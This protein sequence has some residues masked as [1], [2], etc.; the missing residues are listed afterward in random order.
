MKS[1]VAPL[2]PQRARDR[3][4]ERMYRRH[5]ADVYH[6]AL[7]VLH[8]EADAEDVTQTTFLNAYRAFTVGERPDKPKNWLIAIAHNVCRQ[9]FRTAARR[10]KEVPLI[11]ETV[12]DLVDDGDHPSAEDIRRALSHLSFNQRSALVMRE[13]EGRTYNEIA[14]IL[15]LSRSAV[16]TLIF[17]ARRALREQ[18][19]EALTCREAEAALS[20]RADAQLGWGER[21]ALRAHLR[22]CPECARIARRQRAQRVALRG[23]ATA[24]VPSSLAAF[25]AGGTATGGAVVAK[26]AAVAVVGLVVGAGTFTAVEYAIRDEQFARPVAAPPAERARV[27]APAAAP[28]ASAPVVAQRAPTVTFRPPAASHPARHPPHGRALGHPGKA[29]AERRLEARAERAL[30]AAARRHEHRRAREDKLERRAERALVKA[31]R[32]RSSHAPGRAGAG[33][34]TAHTKGGGHRKKGRR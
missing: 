20:R 29:R 1:L 30:V 34:K 28:A 21:R 33:R 17:R 7:A 3:V 23:L 6:Y 10:P 14:Q 22:E 16:E 8:N 13:L 32:H 9:R 25:F 12:A 11:E 18:L 2:F 15:D 27:P 31:S 19:E 5:V 24:P 26:A 4:F